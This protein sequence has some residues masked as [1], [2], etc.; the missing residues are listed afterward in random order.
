MGLKGKTQSPVASAAGPKTSTNT[1]PGKGSTSIAKGKGSKV[2]KGMVRPPGMLDRNN[3][4]GTKGK[5]IAEIERERKKERE[6]LTDT[7]MTG[8]VVEWKGDTLWSR[9]ANSLRI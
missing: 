1:A 3:G 9:L 8:T 2:N 6:R 4:K 5:T 7:P